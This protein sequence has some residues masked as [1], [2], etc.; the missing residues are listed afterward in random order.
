LDAAFHG[1]LVDR[2]TFDQRVKLRY[3]DM[4]HIPG[5][6]VD[7]DLCWS[8]CALEHIGSIEKGL[9]FIENSLKTLKPGGVAIHTTEYNFMRD[10]YTIDNWGVVLFQR[11]HFIELSE[12]LTAA[13][14]RV[15]PL[16]L[17]VGS[18]PLDQ[19]I[20]LPPFPHDL[21]EG[22]RQEW[23]SGVSHIKVSVDGIPCTCFGFIIIKGQG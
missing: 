8:I 2:A 16:D 23:G 9:N 18:K 15:M 1:D 4:N 13:G 10:D 17:R 22:I 3:V 7:Y 20:D 12:R 11:K 21:P 14:H 5:D 19:F 6:L